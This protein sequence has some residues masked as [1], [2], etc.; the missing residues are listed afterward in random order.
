MRHLAAAAL[1]ALAFSL[2]AWAQDAEPATP[3]AQTEPVTA[4]AA[5]L[6]GRA[7]AISTLETM[8]ADVT[9]AMTVGYSGELI[10]EEEI[11][12][13]LLRKH[14]DA[15]FRLSP[16]SVRLV[17][18]SPDEGQVVTWREGMDRMRVNPPGFLPTISI[19]PSGDRAMA[20]SHR[21]VPQFGI[22]LTIDRH[23]SAIGQTAE[24]ADVGVERLGEQ[25]R[26]RQ[27]LEGHE[28]HHP[29]VGGSPVV[30]FTIWVDPATSMPI[31]FENRRADG[32]IYERYRYIAFT[33]N[34]SLSDD[35]FDQ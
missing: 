29:P 5:A 7:E 21:P 11:D 8:R 12:G 1:A 23:L 4:E 24:D 3:E 20:T 34:P 32:S 27:M 10:S 14:L 35:L 9:D 17:F 16:R 18:R 22:D 33:P 25:R 15:W 30:S 13:E 6:S 2:T 31:H 28:F 19:D 26:G